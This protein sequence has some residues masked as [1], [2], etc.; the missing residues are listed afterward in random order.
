MRLFIS[1]GVVI[2]L[3]VLEFYLLGQFGSVEEF[4]NFGDDM[5]GLTIV[6]LAFVNLL[7]I[8]AVIGFFLVP[9]LSEL[10][11]STLFAPVREEKEESP[12]KPAMAAVN[13]GDYEE[14]VDIYLR[15]ARDNTEDIHAVCEAARLTSQK[16]DDTDSAIEM[17]SNWLDAD[18]NADNAAQLAFF[19]AD[20]AARDAHYYDY[21]EGVLNQIIE[22]MPAT[23]HALRA[24]QELKTI[25]KLRVEHA[26]ETGEEEEGS[27]ALPDSEE[28]SSR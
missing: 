9:D 17:L 2:G 5:R 1:L 18:H 25:H 6:G 4:L 14:A 28:T 10:F 12:Y 7:V 26:K 8:V 11:G 24:T 20:M 19:L 3:L 22:S 21:A 15:I 16:L 27:A 23:P 13:R